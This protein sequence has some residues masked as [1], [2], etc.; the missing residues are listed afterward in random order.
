MSEPDLHRY[1][2]SEAEHERIFR[3]EI[4]PTE[5]AGAV[6]QARPVVV[7]VGGQPGAG[8]TATAAM[9]RALL[10]RRGGAAHVCGDVFKPYHPHYER[11][12]RE[13]D[14]TA[15]MYTRLDTRHWHAKAEAYVL[16]E[17]V[18]AVVETAMTGPDGFVEPARRFAAAG[19]RVEAAILAV[20]AALSRLGILARY[21][22]Q[23]EVDERGRAVSKENHDTC[24]RGLVET[25]DQIDRGRLADAVTVYRRGNDVVYRNRLTADRQ[26]QQSPATRAA[27][28]AERARQLTPKAADAFAR[29]LTRLRS[30]LGPRWSADLDEVETL[31]RPLL[32]RSHGGRTGAQPD[33]APD[34]RARPRPRPPEEDLDTAYRERPGHRDARRPPSG[35]TAGGPAL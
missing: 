8:K 30:Q 11:L 23:L 33:P 26:W 18:D 3:E 29:T 1:V 5:L 27:I 12:L 19:Y 2:L 4:V 25:A 16:E 15:G 17:R 35:T 6:S 7:F 28:E 9:I 14:A 34:P 24:Y 21:A 32:P 13:D 10:D 22:R 31:A 20:P